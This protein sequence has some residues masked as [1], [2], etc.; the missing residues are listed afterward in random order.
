MEISP[1]Y[2]IDNARY[3]QKIMLILPKRA[4]NCLLGLVILPGL[5]HDARGD[6]GVNGRDARRRYR[7]RSRKRFS[8]CCICL[9]RRDLSYA[10][11]NLVP[12]S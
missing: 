9:A 3:L 7:Q 8:S 1:F 2:A 4:R 12:P 11:A 10:R 5:S 6:A